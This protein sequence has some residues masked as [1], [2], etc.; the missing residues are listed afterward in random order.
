VGD[1]WFLKK[2]KWRDLIQQNQITLIR[3]EKPPYSRLRMPKQGFK[4]FLEVKGRLLDKGL[5]EPVR[6]NNTVEKN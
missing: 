2:H 4:V 1:W 5:S 3:I 6:R